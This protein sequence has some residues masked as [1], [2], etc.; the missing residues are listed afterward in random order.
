MQVVLIYE[1]A[2]VHLAEQFT[3]NT[4]FVPIVVLTSGI[5]AA[6][7]EYGEDSPFEPSSAV[8]LGAV[9]RYVG[10]TDKGFVASAGGKHFFQMADATTGAREEVI[11]PR[12]FVFLC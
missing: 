4:Y 8:P 12:K 9:F 5:I 11:L 1:K 2:T 3:A 7:D 10:D 6:E